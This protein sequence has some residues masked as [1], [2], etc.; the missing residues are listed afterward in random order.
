MTLHEAAEELGVHYMTVYRYVRHGRL[1]AVKQRGTWH[2]SIADLE[3]FRAGMSGTGTG[4][5][6]AAQADAS[7]RRDAPW[8]ERLEARLV[9]GDGVG[10]WG[11]IETALAA[12]TELDEIYLQML[13]PAMA[14][15]G[16]QWARGDLDIYVEHRATA[17]A[18]RLIGRVGPRFIRRGR[19]KGGVVIGGPSGERHSLPVAMLADLIRLR[20]WDVS[21][22]GADMP[23]A[24]FVQAVSATPD[25]VAVGVS[26]MTEAGLDAAQETL[27][28]VRQATDGLLLVVGG[29]A[30]RDDAHGRALGADATAWGV[31]GFVELLEQHRNA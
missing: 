21:D 9:A 8:A 28:A 2:V 22:L 31:E 23:P 24:P 6:G 5:A 20:G 16:E 13:A 30:I 18:L 25:V 7:V 12:G 11:V 3:A 1:H 14:S 17:I 26:V 10:S 4:A 19:S 15:I 27:Y 29:P